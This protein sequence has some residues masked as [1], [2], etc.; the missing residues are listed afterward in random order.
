MKGIAHASQLRTDGT[1]HTSLMVGR[2]G[3]LLGGVL[4]DHAGTTMALYGGAAA[5]LSTWLLIA[6]AAPVRGQGAAAPSADEASCTR[7]PAA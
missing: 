6:I 5:A 2:A 3:A 4:I 7:C 1:L